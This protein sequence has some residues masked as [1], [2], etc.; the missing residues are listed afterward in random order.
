MSSQK[1]LLLG[2]VQLPRESVEVAE[3]GQTFTVQ[4]MNGVDRDAFESS[5]MTT[6]ANGKKRMFNPAN[7]RAKL[8]VRSLIDPDTGERLFGDGDADALGQVRSDILD[9]LFGV[10]QRLSGI[11]DQD[12]EALTKK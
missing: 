3:L 6:S 1:D 10:A 7:I 9:R 8:L 5:L 11:S 4:G 12:V 2:A